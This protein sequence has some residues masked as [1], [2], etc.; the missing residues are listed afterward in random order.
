MMKNESTHAFL[1][2]QGSR[3]YTDLKFLG[4]PADYFWSLWIF[5]I[6]IVIQCDSLAVLKTPKSRK[7]TLCKLTALSVL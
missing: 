2:K 1:F 4:L 7:T 3:R 5:N 6:C